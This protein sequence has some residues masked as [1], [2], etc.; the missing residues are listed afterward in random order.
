MNNG[1]QPAFPLQPTFNSDG[2]ICEEHYAFE[3]ITKREYFA[4]MAIQSCINS[5]VSVGGSAIPK[6]MA[7]MALEYADALLAALENDKNVQP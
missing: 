4:A 6:A 1:Q 3:G 7:E 5:A 2:Q